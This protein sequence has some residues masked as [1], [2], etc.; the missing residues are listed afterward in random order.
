MKQLKNKLILFYSILIV[1]SKLAGQSDLVPLGG[2]GLF[3]DYSISYSIGQTFYTAVSQKGYYVSFGVQQ[4]SVHNPAN[5]LIEET[6]DVKA[7]YALYPNP[8]S[9]HFYLEVNKVDNSF[10]LIKLFDVNGREL[11]C[12]EIPDIKTKI[13]M[14]NYPV[15]SY[16]LKIF[17]IENELK[18]FLIIKR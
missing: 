5:N 17:S 16:F 2:D 13:S 14:Q 8:V 11:L 1:C 12:S 18:S 15:G 4:P 7:V 3:N 10:I 6:V 9:D